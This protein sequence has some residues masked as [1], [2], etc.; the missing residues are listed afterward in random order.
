MNI[1]RKENTPSESLV[2]EADAIEGASRS[3]GIRACWSYALSGETPRK[4]Y[5]EE[6]N[7]KIGGCEGVELVTGKAGGRI[8][9]PLGSSI[10]PSSSIYLVKTIRGKKYRDVYIRGGAGMG[11]SR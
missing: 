3:H 4:A 2:T 11:C 6:N 9:G 10:F 8:K 5:L 7:K 1:I